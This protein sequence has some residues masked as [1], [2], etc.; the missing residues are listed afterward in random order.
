MSEIIMR[1]HETAT[2]A[3]RALL[4][5]VTASHHQR[6]GTAGNDIF[7]FGAPLIYGAPTNPCKACIGFCDAKPACIALSCDFTLS[8]TPHVLGCVADPQAS[9]RHPDGNKSAGQCLI[10]SF[11]D[12]LSAWLTVRKP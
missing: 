5:A 11:P 12:Y 8:D 10:I 6:N 2:W 3:G 9:R 1:R 7:H 4:M